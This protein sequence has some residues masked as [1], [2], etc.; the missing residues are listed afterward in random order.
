MPAIKL[1][2]NTKPPLLRLI[3]ASLIGVSIGYFLFTEMDTK[4]TG[5]NST[6]KGTICLV[7]D[8]FGFALN[9]DVEEFFRLNDNITVAIIPGTLYAESIGIYA[10]SIGV[11]TIIH[12]PM[13]SHEKD[14]TDYPISLNE[15][16]N[17]ALVE[18]RIR[19]AFEEV[20][21][22]LGMNNHQ[23][24]KATENLQLMK[25]LART[26]KK[27]N[28]FFLDSFTN[29]E[30]RG[31]ITMRR[32]GVPTQLRQ[33][34]LDHVEDPIQIKYNLDSLA[35]LSHDMDIAVGIGHVKPITLKVLKKEIPRLESEG[36]RFIRLSQAVR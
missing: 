18:D 15:K 10:D 20:P 6:V 34:F 2:N 27:M 5:Q 1:S 12:M 21:T 3:I 36:Y 14:E 8:D 26:L 25:D 13:E 16:L 17:A 24:S 28:K 4:Q 19:F 32:Y 31:Y 29:P 11:E 9:S 23:G 7:I 33:V 30:S 22:A 35:T